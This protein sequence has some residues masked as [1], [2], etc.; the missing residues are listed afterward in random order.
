MGMLERTALINTTFPAGFNQEEPQA[1]ILS[2]NLSIIGC[3]LEDF[4]ADINI[5]TPKYLKASH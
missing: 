1:F 3:R 5:G 2:F 4:G